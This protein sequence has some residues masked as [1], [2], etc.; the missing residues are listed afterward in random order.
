MM[1]VY[2]L[3]VAPCC[4][5]QPG[6]LGSSLLGS[7]V[8][9]ELTCLEEAGWL[10]GADGGRGEG[11][12]ETDAR[13]T[14]LVCRGRELRGTGKGAGLAFQPQLPLFS[15]TYL[16]SRRFPPYPSGPSL[17]LTARGLVWPCG[18]FTSCFHA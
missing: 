12:C 4:S 18:L 2:A 9:E 11:L 14:R 5:P 10:T 6:K 13:L 8:T 17:L 7:W 1:C 16:M 15:V 3:S